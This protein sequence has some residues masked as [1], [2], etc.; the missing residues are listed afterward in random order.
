MTFTYFNNSKEIYDDMLFEIERAKESISLQ[1]YIY[2]KDYLGEKFLNVLTKKAKQGVNVMLLVD[3]WGS[4]GVTHSFFKHLTDAGGKVNFFRPIKIRIDFNNVRRNH[5]RNHRKLLVIDEKVSYLGS[6]NIMG[7]SVDWKEYVVKIND[8][9]LS[10]KLKESIDEDDKIKNTLFY[11]KQKHIQTI[12]YKDVEIIKDIPSY[13]HQLIRKKYIELIDN[14]KKEITLEHS[15]F[16]PDKKVLRALKRAKK[17]GVNIIILIPRHSDVRIFDIARQYLFGKYYKNGYDLYFYEKSIMHSKIM[18]ID[19]IDIVIGSTNL[20][21]RSLKYQFEIIF[22]RKNKDDA[23][24]LKEMI[25]EDLKYSKKFDYVEWKARPKIEK[26]L[27]FL[28]YKLRFL[29]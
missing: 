6:I 15:Y 26:I 21:Y 19:D 16:F 13:R 2:S 28:L 24:V 9:Y 22:H 1:T 20:D 25:K 18:V 11:N 29:L 10:Q 27:E 4:Y 7:E 5:R 23:K 3:A 14:A 17:R 8:S 12:I